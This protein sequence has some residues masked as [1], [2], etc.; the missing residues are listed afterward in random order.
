[1]SRE[2]LGGKAGS[3]IWKVARV[4][5]FAA[6]GFL[7]FRWRRKIAAFVSNQNFIITAAYAVILAFIALFYRLIMVLNWIMQQGH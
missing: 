4:L 1:M 2:T 3:I 5:T 6:G 7:F